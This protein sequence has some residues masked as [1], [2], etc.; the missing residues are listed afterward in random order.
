M[1]VSH[2]DRIV[3]ADPTRHLW[4]IETLG[5]LFESLAVITGWGYAYWRAAGVA[6]I[7]SARES[8][9][10]IRRGVTPGGQE[11]PRRSKPH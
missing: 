9:G 6:A 11:T 8:L 4:D 2:R 10:R 1:G 7:R 3:D 5:L